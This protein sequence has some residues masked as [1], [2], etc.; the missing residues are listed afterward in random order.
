MALTGG[1]TPSIPGQAVISLTALLTAAAWMGMKHISLEEAGLAWTRRTVPWTLAAAVLALPGAALWAWSLGGMREDAAEGTRMWLV[2]AGSQ[3]FWVAIP[4]EI[5]FRGALQG[6]LQRG[7]KPRHPFPPSVAW[8]SLLFALT[9]VLAEHSIWG[10]RVAVPGILFGVLRTRTGSI[11]APVLVHAA[12][13]VAL[14]A[15]QGRLE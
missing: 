6:L 4:E 10:L 15:F 12:S 3:L 2:F 14:A 13:N 5:L 11:L 9:H 7:E 1:M 8:S